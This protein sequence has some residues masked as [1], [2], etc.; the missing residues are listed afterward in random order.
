MKTTHFFIGTLL[1]ASTCVLHA[2]SSAW[3]PKKKLLIIALGDS[4]TAGTPFFQSPLE[5]PPDGVGDP[6]G[7]YIYWMARKHPDWD[8][9]NFGI[10]GERSDQIRARFDDVLA[11]RPRYIIILAG[12]NDIYQRYP[13]TEIGKNLLWMY[14]QAKD[15]NII[16]IAGT[17]SPFNRATPQQRAELDELNRWII[18][19]AD[20]LLIPVVNFSALTVDPADPH[21]LNDSPDG[22][23]PDVPGYR[24]MGLAATAV[25]ERMEKVVRR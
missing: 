1:L 21:R 8:I 10:A 5:S 2:D 20:K 12:V 14:Q 13:M 6:Q 17:V 9:R 18:K 19:A 11:L 3:P 25:I 15:R 16:P 24:K 4:T 23:H 7:Q 22:L